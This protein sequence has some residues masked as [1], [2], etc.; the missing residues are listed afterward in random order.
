[1]IYANEKG[2]S[3]FHLDSDLIDVDN[4]GYD[5]L[6]IGIGHGSAHHWIFIN[7]DGNFTEDNR[8]KMMTPFTEL[9]TKCLFLL[10]LLTLIMMVILM[11][12]FYGQDMNLIMPDIIFN[13]I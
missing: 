13:L 3:N 11:L 4:D 10:F 5:D 12:E 6:L 1:M 7:D 8:I 9:I 2:H